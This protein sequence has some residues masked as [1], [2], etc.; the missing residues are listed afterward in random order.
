MGNNL[1]V[2]WT[3]QINT[4]E[5][6]NSP[7]LI[8]A[9]ALSVGPGVYTQADDLARVANWYLDASV[10]STVM[11]KASTQDKLKKYSTFPPLK[12][13]LRFF[14]AVYRC[15]KLQ[16]SRSSPKDVFKAEYFIIKY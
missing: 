12:F 9:S 13:L 4:I 5:K 8:P 1:F 6:A 16:S 7:I 3:K 11:H 10:M 15:R 2:Y 14:L